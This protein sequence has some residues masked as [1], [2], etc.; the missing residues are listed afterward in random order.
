MAGEEEPLTKKARILWSKA[1]D[2]WMYYH[3]QLKMVPEPMAP[4]PTVVASEDEVRRHFNIIRH[5][6]KYVQK[7]QIALQDLEEQSVE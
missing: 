1:D 5:Q 7:Q 6:I 2:A 4:G 3:L